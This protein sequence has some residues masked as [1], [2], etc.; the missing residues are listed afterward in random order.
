MHYYGP[1][2]YLPRP[3]HLYNRFNFRQIK[4]T[5]R[6]LQSIDELLPNYDFEL[7][8]EPQFLPGQGRSQTL[9]LRT[10]Q[11]KKIVK[12]YKS[13][14]I[15]PTIIYEHS[16]LQ[17]LAQI[18][19]P[20]PRLV[21]TKTNE[22]L[23]TYDHGCYALFD[24][25]EG[26]LQYHQYILLPRQLRQFIAIGGK[27]LADL[28]DKLQHH[29]P[30]GYNPSGFKSKTGERWRNLDWYTKRLD[31]CL[32]KT[33][34][35]IENEANH[36]LA[37]LWQNHKI[38]EQTFFKL[39]TLLEEACL[40]RL[41]IHGDYGPYN[42]LFRKNAPAIVI[43]FELTRLDWRLY[44]LTDSLWRFGMDRFVGFNSSKMKIFMDAY[45]SHFPIAL[46]ELRHLP[47]VW[48]Y[49]HLLRAIKYW[50]KYCRTPTPG[51]LKNSYF[52][53]DMIEYMNTNQDDL[54]TALTK[55]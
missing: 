4:P 22:S 14:V 42:L 47:S 51:L 36:P 23:L 39:N 41:I 35:L 15:E 2:L 38:I 53:L 31:F 19:F 46:E 26:G 43:D 5:K 49:I 18:D 17:Y 1:Q 8:N 7:T 3:H 45:Q 28:H 29:T 13:T 34:Q 40:P 32:T 44:E 50:Y 54:M 55:M 12:R 52:H 11:G 33:S 24:F 30:T 21:L 20:A 27:L 25:I 10:S 16:V 48:K 9:I 37:R 6:I